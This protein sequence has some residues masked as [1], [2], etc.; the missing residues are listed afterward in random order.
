MVS[1]NP[2]KGDGLERPIAYASWNKNKAASAGYS[3]ELISDRVDPKYYEDLWSQPNPLGDIDTLYKVY[4]R[5][6][7][8][9]PN[10][11][12][13][14]TRPKTGSNEKGQPI[15]GDYE[16]MTYS[17]FDKVVANFS[18]GL[19]KLDLIPEVEGEGKKWRFLGIWAKNRWEWTC[20]LI[21]CMHYSATTVG[22]FDAMGQEQVDFILKQT[23]M[24]TILCSAQYLGKVID[25]KKAGLA[26][27]IKNL[28]MM[29]DVPEDQI[30]M[31]SEFDIKVYTFNQVIEEGGKG[32]APAFIEPK[33][34]DAYIFSYT[35]GTTGDSKGVKLT[36]QNIICNAIASLAR[37]ESVEGDRAISYLPF[38]HSFE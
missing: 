14:G 9:S 33:L 2:A 7:A 29:D 5:N 15:F 26:T 24:Q 17:D 18:K 3:Q 22:F 38:T 6:V 30:K 27:F 11:E 23:E 32:G 19:M 20:G 36:H 8:E 16:W 37:L 4:R 12:F 13:L 21:G 1:A 35:S 34:D 31:A 25:M 28:I 10:M